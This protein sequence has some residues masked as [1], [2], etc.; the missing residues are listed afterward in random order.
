MWVE[1]KFCVGFTF[2]SRSEYVCVCFCLSVS[3]THSQYLSLSHYLTHFLTH[4][5]SPS[6]SLSPILIRSWCQDRNRWDLCGGRLVA[7]AAAPSYRTATR[8][9]YM[10]VRMCVCQKGE[11]IRETGESKIVIERQR[12]KQKQI[13]IENYP[14]LSSTHTLGF[15][16]S[17]LGHLACSEVSFIN[18]LRSVLRIGLL[19][20]KVAHKELVAGE[21][22]S[23]VQRCVSHPVLM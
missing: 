4:P 21:N 14:I 15:K 12:Q 1:L 17:C 20:L 2:V 7:A 3:P 18:N 11:G 9:W 23:F 13:K 16:A 8:R 6:H 19:P 10:C 5:L 22:Q